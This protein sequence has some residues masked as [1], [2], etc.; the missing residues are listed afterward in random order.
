MELLLLQ[1]FLLLFLTNMAKGQQL[2]NQRQIVPVEK[3]NVLRAY[4]FYVPM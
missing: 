4:V 2:I 3:I 1:S